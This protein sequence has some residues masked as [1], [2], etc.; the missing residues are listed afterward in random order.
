MVTCSLEQCNGTATHEVYCDSTGCLE[1]YLWSP[2]EQQWEQPWTTS[3]LIEDGRPVEHWLHDLRQLR[4]ELNLTQE[5]CTDLQEGMEG[6]LT[7]I[8]AL[9][10]MEV[11]LTGPTKVKLM[12]IVEKVREINE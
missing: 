2:C 7:M 12:A 4:K 11:L 3:S 1:L 10:G 5:R 8:E 9:L 6:A